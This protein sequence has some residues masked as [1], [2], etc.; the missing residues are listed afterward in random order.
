MALSHAPTKSVENRLIEPCL[1]GTTHC[2]L[3]H[4][5]P[6][7]VLWKIGQKGHLPGKSRGAA[8][9]REDSADAGR[10]D[11]GANTPTHFQQHLRFSAPGRLRDS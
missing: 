7:G 1:R 2:L 9:W 10:L 8:L 4:R 6:V 3:A 5:A 11:L